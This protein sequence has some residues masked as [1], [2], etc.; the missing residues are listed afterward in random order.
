MSSGHH[1]KDKSLKS[2]TDTLKI[3]KRLT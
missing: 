3:L 1:K 2:V